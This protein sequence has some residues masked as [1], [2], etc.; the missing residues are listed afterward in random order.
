MSVER[1]EAIVGG[2]QMPVQE[3]FWTSWF[4]RRFRRAHAPLGVSTALARTL[5]GP[6]TGQRLDLQTFARK[7]GPGETLRQVRALRCPAPL[8]RP[9]RKTRRAPRAAWR[10]RAG[11]YRPRVKP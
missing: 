11:R 8:V 4:G 10:S 2:I 1:S 5:R 7:A 9:S 6:E 3:R